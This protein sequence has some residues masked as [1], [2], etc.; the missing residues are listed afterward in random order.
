MKP[1]ALP[2]VPAVVLALLATGCSGG[3]SG[4]SKDT[5]PTRAQA[6]AAAKA[7][8]LTSADAPS[9]FSATPA[10]NGT[11]SSDKDIPRSI[12]KCLG[13]DAT[14]IDGTSDIVD[15]QSDSL[16]KG[17]PPAGISITSET[18]VVK[19]K[20]EVKKVMD[21]YRGDKTLDCVKTAAN[22]SLTASIQK[23]ASGVKVSFGTISVTRIS[24]S[25]DGTD[26]TFGFSIKLP[27]SATGI[28]I[29]VQIDVLAF[30]KDHTEVSLNVTSF[31]SPLSDSDR[32]GLYAKLVAR[33]KTSAV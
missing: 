18:E 2:A 15:Q 29:P 9:G 25:A 33:A 16:D 7:I 6:Q 26:G 30:A 32:D 27:L 14:L 22:A 31:G 1:L 8:N 11:D 12:A 21:L 13:V 4:S 20:A 3:S 10:D 5:A 19:T 17:Q 28:S 24:P 23:S